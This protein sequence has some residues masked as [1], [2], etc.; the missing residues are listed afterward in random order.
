MTGVFSFDGGIMAQGAQN[1]ANHFRF[2]T[3]YF[4]YNNNDFNPILTIGLP[5]VA[6]AAVAFKISGE[7]FTAGLL[8]NAVYMI[9]LF[10][11][12]AYYIKY[13]LKLGNYYILLALLLFFGTK[14]IFDLGFGLYGEIPMCFYIM[15]VFIFIHKYSTDRNRKKIFIAGVFMGLGFITKTVMLAIIPAIVS[16]ELW[17]RFMIDRDNIKGKAYTGGYFVLISG[18]MLPVA[19]EETYKLILLGST[20][21]FKWWSGNIFGVGIHAGIVKYSGMSDTHGLILKYNRHIDLLAAQTGINR[22]VLTVLLYLLIFAFLG[23]LYYS[24]KYLKNKK[25][26]YGETVVYDKSA[27]MIMCMTVTYFVWWLLITPTGRAW[28]RRIITGVIFYDICFVFIIYILGSLLKKY[29]PAGGKKAASVLAYIVLTAFFFVSVW[30]IVDNKNYELPLHDTAE[31]SNI[32]AAGKFIKSLPPEA[33]CY[34][35]AWW[36]A[37]DISFASGKVFKNILNPDDKEMNSSGDKHEKYLVVDRWAMESEGPCY[38]KL[39]GDY[40]N[41]LVFSNDEARIYKLSKRI[42]ITRPEECN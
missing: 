22:P 16:I 21:F 39:A 9:M 37:P 40:E 29:A 11:S 20:G 32:M 30:R 10:L 41:Q 6:P 33:Q 26:Q 1:M 4:L 42:K 2:A 24:Y 38:I 23:V 17:D 14:G 25:P 8:V 31:K 36:Q 19:L 18:I 5:V 34:G 12:I 35:F 13:C 28:Y 7:S 3:S 27:L 15:T